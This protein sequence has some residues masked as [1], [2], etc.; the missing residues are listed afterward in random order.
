MSS[1][2][3]IIANSKEGILGESLWL[4]WNVS[5]SCIER[6]LGKSTSISII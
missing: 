3:G 6:M 4:G 2:L 1:T 5:V